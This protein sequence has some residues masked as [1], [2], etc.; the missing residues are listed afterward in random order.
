M[1]EIT[2]NR[3]RYTLE[4]M[5]P[6]KDGYIHDDFDFRIPLRRITCLTCVERIAERRA[7][8]RREAFGKGSAEVARHTRLVA[9][10]YMRLAEI[11]EDLKL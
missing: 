4:L 7:R 5:V 2:R 11:E 6:A 3:D 1:Q 9:E 10:P 8:K